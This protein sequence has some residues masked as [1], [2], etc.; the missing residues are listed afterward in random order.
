MR[1]WQNLKAIICGSLKTKVI[2]GVCVILAT[3]MGIYTY[4]DAVRRIRFHLNREEVKAF[5]LTNVVTKS[6]QYPML[7]GQMEDV[8]AILESV[9]SLD[10]IVMVDIC[11]ASK[12]IRYS[13][14]PDNML[15]LGPPSGRGPARVSLEHR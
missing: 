15:W 2:F 7:D 4:W 6:I 8:Q 11:D 1:S 10:S 12:T 5:E 9:T 14:N 13:G 3:V